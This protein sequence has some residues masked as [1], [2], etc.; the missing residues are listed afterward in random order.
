MGD[1]VL[2][3]LDGHVATITY[4]RPDALN[5]I[6]GQLRHDL[7][8]AFTRFRDEDDA[9]VAIVTGAGR[10]RW[11]C[12]GPAS[13]SRP[14][15][16]ERSA[17]RDGSA[18]TSRGGTGRGRWPRGGWRPR[19]WPSGRRGRWRCGAAPPPP[20]SPAGPAGDQGGGG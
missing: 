3:E 8:A 17:W 18:R 15:A 7:N 20:W 16:P 19:R 12:S 13:A 2:Y 9:G 10:A 6:N 4:N 14:R 1:A 11:R 5:A